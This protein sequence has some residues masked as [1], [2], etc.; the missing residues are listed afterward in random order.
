MRRM[1]LDENLGL[2]SRSSRLRVSP[3]QVP[4]EEKIFSREGAKVSKR[5]KTRDCTLDEFYG[6]RIARKSSGNVPWDQAR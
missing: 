1:A 2:A 4:I 6:N 3:L 5:T